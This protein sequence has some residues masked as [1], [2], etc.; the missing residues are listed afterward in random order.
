MCGKREGNSES[1]DTPA[2]KWKDNHE[3]SVELADIEAGL[4]AADPA[5]GCAT[6]TKRLCV[7]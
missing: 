5:G 4:S 7:S 2:A 3:T 6:Q 1:D